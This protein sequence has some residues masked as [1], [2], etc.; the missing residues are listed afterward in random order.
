MSV[1]AFPSKVKRR[2]RASRPGLTA[3]EIEWWM[4]QDEIL[5]VT[6]G[7]T[8]IRNLADGDEDL[9][10]VVGDKLV[11]IFLRAVREMRRGH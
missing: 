2:V 4:D 9:G 10:L 7:E 6:P 5:H 1:V 3:Q 11:V 8:I